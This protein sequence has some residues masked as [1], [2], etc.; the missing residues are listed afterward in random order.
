MAKFY[1]GEQKDLG[2]T[3][4]NIVRKRQKRITT[5][6]GFKYGLAG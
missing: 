4:Q 5:S 6:A 2:Y 3:F 1:E